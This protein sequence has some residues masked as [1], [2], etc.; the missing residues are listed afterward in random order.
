MNIKN[1]VP[2]SAPSE[3]LVFETDGFS[4]R[5]AVIKN[6]GKSP[7]VVFTANS[8]FADMAEAVKEIA[9]QLKQNGFK[10]GKAILL[11]PAVLSTLVEL[12]INPKKSRPIPQMQELIRWE[13][14]P[15]LM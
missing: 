10:G 5:A 8:S 2:F 3:L 4:L 1:L 6:A 13:V 15:L 7:Q 11:S 9:E 12:P 14:E